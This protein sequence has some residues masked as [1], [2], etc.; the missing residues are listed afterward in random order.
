MT[1]YGSDLRDLHVCA[2]LAAS[3]QENSMKL[4]RN[5]VL[6]FAVLAVLALAPNTVFADGHWVPIEGSFTVLAVRPAAPSPITGS[7]CA[8]GIGTP[9]EAQGI[10]SV[11][12]LGPMF[13]TVKKCLTVVNGQGTYLGTFTMVAGDGD[14][15]EGRVR[16]VSDAQSHRRERLQ[17]VSRDADV[18]WRNRQ[19]RPRRRTPQLH[20]CRQPVLD[21][22]DCADRQP[23]GVLSGSGTHGVSRSGLARRAPQ[24]SCFDSFRRHSRTSSPRSSRSA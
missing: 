24:S 8:G 14:T 10:G 1:R 5:A 20:R 3:T 15:L 22:R 9:F 13:L 7:Y 4:I 6:G 23:D 12:K 19:V 18:Y 2:A 16:R 17:A 21:R 11:S